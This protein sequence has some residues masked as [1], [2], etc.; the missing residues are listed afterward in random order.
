MIHYVDVLKIPNSRVYI[1][2]YVATGILLIVSVVVSVAGAGRLLWHMFNA[3]M[4][5]VDR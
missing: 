3:C 2:Y 4:Y 1:Q 5:I